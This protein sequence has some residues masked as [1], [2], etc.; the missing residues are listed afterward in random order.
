MLFSISPFTTVFLYILLFVGEQYTV[1]AISVLFSM[2]PLTVINDTS[3]L[4]N[5]CPLP[6]KK[7]ARKHFSQRLQ[8]S[9]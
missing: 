3:F 7:I 2:F 9:K 5:L 4:P 6:L 1:S 8:S